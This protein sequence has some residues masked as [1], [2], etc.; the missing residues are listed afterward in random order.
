M[1]LTTQAGWE[2]VRARAL[3]SSGAAEATRSSHDSRSPCATFRRT[4]LT[5]VAAPRP[6]A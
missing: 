2:W 6:A 1:A 5:K 4:A 3:T